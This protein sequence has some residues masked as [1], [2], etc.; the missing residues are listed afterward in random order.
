MRGDIRAYP[1]ARPHH[2]NT[3]AW[4]TALDDE[5]MG[6]KVGG[7]ASTEES[8]MRQAEYALGVPTRRVPAAW[9]EHAHLAP[10]IAVALQHTADR[11]GLDLVDH[12]DVVSETVSDLR[13]AGYSHRQISNIPIED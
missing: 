6:A 1:L 9:A 11:L 8:A 7:F 2:G 5:P 3:W 10:H 12:Y 13:A 4:E